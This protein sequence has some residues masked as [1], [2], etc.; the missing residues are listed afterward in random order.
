MKLYYVLFISLAFY[1]SSYSQR[2]L[3]GD[4]PNPENMVE[5]DPTYANLP[6]P[7]EILVVIM[8]TLRIQI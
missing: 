6:L 7:S 5:Q 2:L 1:F 4:D 8:Q 3:E